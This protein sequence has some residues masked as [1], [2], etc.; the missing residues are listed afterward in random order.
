MKLHSS[1]LTV[2]TVQCLQCTPINA[3]SPAPS[4][5]RM[6]ELFGLWE[7]GEGLDFIDNVLA[8]DCRFAVPGS[9]RYAGVYDREGI[10]A[11]ELEVFEMF[12]VPETISIGRIFR[13][14]DGHWA[15]VSMASKEGSLLKNGE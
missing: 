11:V 13:D 9:H 5:E 3:A 6:R 14:E 1:L 8:P 7:T 15:S 2:L 10:K 12:R 4:V